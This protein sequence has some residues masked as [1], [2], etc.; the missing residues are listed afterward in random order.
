MAHRRNPTLF[1]AVITEE[2]PSLSL[3]SMRSRRRRRAPP[4]S[5][6]FLHDRLA[7]TS[8]AWAH[9]ELAHAL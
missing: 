7:A 6:G 1:S 8:H 2:Q 9:V 5:A 4:P 3:R